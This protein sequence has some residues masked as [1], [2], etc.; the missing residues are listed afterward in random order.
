MDE[1]SGKI[2]KDHVIEM[3]KFHRLQASPYFH[4]AALYVKG[5]LEKIDIRFHIEISVRVR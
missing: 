2:A 1:F 4:D 5:A 3:S